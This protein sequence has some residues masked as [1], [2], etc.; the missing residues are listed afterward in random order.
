MKIIY[1]ILIASLINFLIAGCKKDKTESRYPEWSE[2]RT[3]K[4]GQIWK[5]NAFAQIDKKRS[6]VIS[7]PANISNNFGELREVLM[8]G[9]IPFELGKYTLLKKI[10]NSDILEIYASY[11]TL[12]ADGDVV[13]DRYDVLEEENNFI[14]ID[15]IDLT[16]M[17][18]SGNF[19]VTFVRDPND[20]VSNPSLPDTIRFNE[21][22]FILKIIGI[23]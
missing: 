3:L 22:V 7:I 15:T 17:K 8:L 23:N 20:H 9:D 18:M 14:E 12:T 10:L 11:T 5:S 2:V 19:Q 6:G 21:G 16:N 13:E 1:F 4:N